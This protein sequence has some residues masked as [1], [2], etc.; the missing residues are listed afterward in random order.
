MTFHR[1]GANSTLR[2]SLRAVDG[3]AVIRMEDRFSTDIDDMWS[4]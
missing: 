2:G 4:R 1:T 3:K